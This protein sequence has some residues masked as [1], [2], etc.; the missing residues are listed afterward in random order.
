M[1]IIINIK[2]KDI[3]IYNLNNNTTLGVIDNDYGLIRY[4]FK[5]LEEYELTKTKNGY[6]QFENKEGE[7]YLHRIIMEYY[8]QFDDK[9]FTILNNSEFEVNHKNK[10]KWDNRLENLEMVTRLG[11]ERHRRGVTYKDE[12]VF[13]TKELFKIKELN[14]KDKDRK[15]LEK[16]SKRN[17]EFLNSDC[18]G[19]T[20]NNEFY[21]KAYIKLNNIATFTQ[22]QASNSICMNTLEEFNYIIHSYTKNTI[23]TYINVE[24]LKGEYNYHR[25]KIMCKNNMQLIDKYYKKNKYFRHIC[26]KYKLMNHIIRDEKGELIYPS[27]IEP[28]LLIFIYT[29]LTKG[30]FHHAYYKN[31]PITNLDAQA[32]VLNYKKYD[33]FKV[34][35]LLELFHRISTKTS[36]HCQLFYSAHSNTKVKHTPYSFYIPKY[37]DRLFTTTVLPNSKKLCNMNLSKI[38]HTIVAKNFGLD[39]ANQVYKNPYRTKITLH[40]YISIDDIKIL[41]TSSLLD[42]LNN[43]GFITVNQIRRALKDLNEERKN[44]SLPSIEVYEDEKTKRFIHRNLEEYE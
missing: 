32:V 5:I 17:L 9:L 15:Y 25:F 27:H 21:S 3:A 4:L 38:T 28:N 41:I 44:Q 40:N 39:V 22:L 20:F 13:N 33:S 11:N 30:T 24:M 37:T 14:I 18:L 19:Y 16:L 6:L 7:T 1:D 36:S 23:F 31:H 43:Y 12:I 29:N 8:A 35:F 34:L 10:K 2:G 42:Q 26:N